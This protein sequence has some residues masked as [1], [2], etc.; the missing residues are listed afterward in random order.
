MLSD[1]AGAMLLSTKPNP[2]GFS[3]RLDWIDIFSYAN[4]IDTCMCFGAVKETEG[5]NR[6]RL[7]SWAS[8]PLT[9]E[10]APLFM[11]IKQDVKLLNDNIVRLTVDKTLPKVISKRF[12][13]AEDYAYF[14]PHYSSHYF[15]EKL[16]YGM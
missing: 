15:R 14:L 10:S 3:L 7:K 2:S 16:N 11:S 13:R 4:E 8:E 9:T 12:I 5:P 1:G 6:G